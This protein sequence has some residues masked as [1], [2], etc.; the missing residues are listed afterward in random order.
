ML[1]MRESVLSLKEK[2][3]QPWFSY[4]Q[5]ACMYLKYFM[6]DPLNIIFD[7]FN[8]WL[9]SYRIEFR[10]LYIPQGHNVISTLWLWSTGEYVF[11]LYFEQISTF[12]YLRKDIMFNH[13]LEAT[14][15][16]GTSEKTGRMWFS[17]ILYAR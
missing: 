16:L 1:L 7:N 4:F 8:I 11:I 5:I 9:L 14:L 12:K 17:I 10:C 2:T 3:T 13:R 6:T 15:M